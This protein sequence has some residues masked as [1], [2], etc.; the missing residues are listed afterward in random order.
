M[1]AKLWHVLNMRGRDEALLDNAVI[2]N[3]FV[4]AA[5]ALCL[6]LIAAAVYLPGLSHVLSTVPP[7]PSGWALSLG[8]SVAPLLLGQAA[9]SA[10]LIE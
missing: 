4:G 5:L 6:V 9:K 3:P 7:G 10:G 2:R 8:L 1:L